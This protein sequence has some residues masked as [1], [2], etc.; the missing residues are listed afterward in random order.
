MRVPRPGSAGVTGSVRST[1]GYGMSDALASLSCTIGPFLPLTTAT[2]QSGSVVG[3]VG[4]FM[5]YAAGMGLVVGVVTVAT[6]LAR[7]TLLDRLR[8]VLPVVARAGGGLVVLAGLY[9]AYY[10]RYEIRVL[11]GGDTA[12]PV[13]DA[14]TGLQGAAQRWLAG[15]GAGPVLLT[16]AVLVAA[17]LAAGG[18][19]SRSRRRS[20][21][22]V[23]EAP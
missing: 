22:D 8:Q 11:S 21:A 15:L 20:P 17:A 19:R 10:G 6:A 23:H 7:H 4:V 2:F 9:V 16:L 18:R 1:V 5:A 14:A 3:G 13:V 12:D